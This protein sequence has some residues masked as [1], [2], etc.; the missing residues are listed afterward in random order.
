MKVSPSELFL[1]TAYT[2]YGYSWYFS[3]IPNK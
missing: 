3:A 1:E 2:G